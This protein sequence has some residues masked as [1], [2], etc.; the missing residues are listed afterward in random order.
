MMYQI[1][2]FFIWYSPFLFPLPFSF[3][4]PSSLYGNFCAYLYSH[5]S[6]LLFF[7]QVIHQGHV[8]IQ[9]CPL[10]GPGRRVIFG[11]VARC[12]SAVPQA[13]CFSAPRRGCVYPMAPGLELSL[14]ANV[15]RLHLECTICKLHYFTC[16]TSLL[17]LL[18]LYS[19]LK[20]EHKHS[21]LIHLRLF[22]SLS[23]NPASEMQRKA[24][25][26]FCFIC[27]SIELIVFTT[28]SGAFLLHATVHTM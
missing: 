24:E 21:S 7:V 5:M 18:N 23:S 26:V 1:L 28:I 2:F 10:M 6:M 9:V 27:D 14:P 12:T 8:E 3:S 13:M 19:F 17:V 11:S 20:Q 25:L 4:L 22:S 16:L 15:S